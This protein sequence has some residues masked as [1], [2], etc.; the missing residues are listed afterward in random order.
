MSAF[1]KPAV[2]YDKANGGFV[3]R[4]C[5]PTV[6]NAALFIFEALGERSKNLD[7]NIGFEADRFAAKNDQL[8]AIWR[9]VQ[10]F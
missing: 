5:R 7:L 10:R 3:P 9:Q 1:P 2:S 8:H 6:E 4:C